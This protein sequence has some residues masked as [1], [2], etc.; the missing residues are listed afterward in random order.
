MAAVVWSPSLRTEIKK[1]KLLSQA[2][3]INQND[4]LQKFSPSLSAQ[5]VNAVKKTFSV[6]ANESAVS[7]ATYWH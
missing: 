5:E 1:L 6:Q 3:A 2:E 4:T 7:P